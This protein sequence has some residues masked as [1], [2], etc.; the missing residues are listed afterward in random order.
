[1]IRGPEP[2]LLHAY[3]HKS[4]ISLLEINAFFGNSHY[5]DCLKSKV[6][7]E[8]SRKVMSEVYLEKKRHE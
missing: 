8:G 3:H 6:L 7:L 4:C 5:P 2:G 1:V